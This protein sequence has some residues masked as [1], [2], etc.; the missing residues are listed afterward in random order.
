MITKAKYINEEQTVVL[1]SFEG[2]LTTIMPLDG[3]LTAFTAQYEEFLKTNSIEDF[4]TAENIQSERYTRLEGIFNDKT[5]GLKK[6]AIDKPFMKN[7][8]AI[9]NQYR[10]YEEMYKNALAGRYDDSTNTAII[11]ANEG[12]K[13]ALASLTL[14]LNSIRAVIEVAITN[15]ATNADELLDIADGVNLTKEELT[16]TKLGELSTVFGL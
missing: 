13:A 11:T 3:N 9:N 12:A 15:D 7:A 2:G 10:I 16:P 6:L 1:L 14:L 4:R 5:M 8:E